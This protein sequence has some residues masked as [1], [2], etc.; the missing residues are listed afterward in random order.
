MLTL[1]VW[2]W[3]AGEVGRCEIGG[4]SVT[5]TIGS[6]IAVIEGVSVDNLP[7]SPQIAALSTHKRVRQR[8]PMRH[9]VMVDQV[10][11]GIEGK[12][13]AWGGHEGDYR[14]DRLL[15]SDGLYIGRV[16]EWEHSRA[17]W[18]LEEEQVKVYDAAGRVFARIEVGELALATPV[19]EA[20]ETRRA[21]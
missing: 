16:F 18:F 7:W 4:L 2:L 20:G 8:L 10:R 5:L 14:G 17:C 12:L 3:G 21:A 13:R 11:E 19:Q 15:L 1:E 6:Q 9:D